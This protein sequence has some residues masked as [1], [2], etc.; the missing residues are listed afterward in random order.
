V[1][2]VVIYQ[3]VRLRDNMPADA[4]CLCIEQNHCARVEP[5]GVRRV[6]LGAGPRLQIDSA[7]IGVT[8][9]VDRRRIPVVVAGVQVRRARDV[10]VVKNGG[11]W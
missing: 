6:L 10:P 7:E 2:E 1:P 4:A 9:L 8:W 3:V 11:W 5:A